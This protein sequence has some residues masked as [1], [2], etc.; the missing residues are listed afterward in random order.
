MK[1][2]RVET[3]TH[4]YGPYAG[5]YVGL[6]VNDEIHPTPESD[7]LL[8][9]NLKD[10][11]NKFETYFFFWTNEYSFGFA[12]YEQFRSWFY[13]DEQLELLIEEDFVLS[14][15]EVDETNVFMGNA[16]IMFNKEKATL[17]EQIPLQSFLAEAA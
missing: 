15:Y 8:S 7:S 11:A 1:V 12:N 3:K 4:G 9:K 6:N 14:A 13:S 16:Q 17:I 5:Q 2:L 10:Y